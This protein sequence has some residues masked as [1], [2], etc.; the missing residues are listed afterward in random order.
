M[1]RKRWKDT[2]TEGGTEGRSERRTEERWKKSRR[3]RSKEGG[4][5]W[6]KGQ[7]EGH[8]KEVRER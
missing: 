1:K 2:R 8:K 3:H 6:M 5:V 7:G 4:E